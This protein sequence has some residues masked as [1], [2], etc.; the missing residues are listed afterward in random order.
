MTALFGPHDLEPD[1]PALLFVSHGIQASA[2][3][4]E[5]G[6]HLRIATVADELNSFRG[7][8]ADSDAAE[9]DY[10]TDER[11]EL[12]RQTVEELVEYKLHQQQ[13]TQL[14]HAK[15]LVQLDIGLIDLTP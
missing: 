2:G 14:Q 1:Y 5:S 4:L 8:R 13:A 15:D 6:H 10:L 7:L 9:R 12:D 3:F 11:V